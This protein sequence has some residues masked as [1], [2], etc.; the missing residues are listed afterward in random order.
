MRHS[1]EI[2]ASDSA[3]RRESSPP[4]VPTQR[5]VLVIAFFSESNL[6]GLILV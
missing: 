5:C 6:K 4:S 1:D 2:G 3:G